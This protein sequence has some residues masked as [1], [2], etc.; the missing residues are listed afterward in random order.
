MLY[1]STLGIKVVEADPNMNVCF[2][3]IVLELSLILMYN[4]V[5]SQM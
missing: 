5:G 3:G 4:K 2:I 1:H